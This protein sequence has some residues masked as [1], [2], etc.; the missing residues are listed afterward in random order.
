MPNC[1]MVRTRGVKKA[2]EVQVSIGWYDT[3]DYS[4]RGIDF[5]SHVGRS[6]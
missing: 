6:S 3:L 2:A 4:V 5:L 1:I